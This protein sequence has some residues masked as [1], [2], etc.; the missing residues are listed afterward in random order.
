MS[1]AAATPPRPT[2]IF[3]HRQYSPALGVD[4]AAIPL[5]D[6]IPNLPEASPPKGLSADH[7]LEREKGRRK[8]LSR[9]RTQPRARRP[10]RPLPQ[11][12]AEKPRCKPVDRSA[13]RDAACA[14][15]NRPLGQWG[16]LARTL[17]SAA[18]RG[19]S[20]S[21]FLLA[22][23]V[24]PSGGVR[25]RQNVRCSAAA[26]QPARVPFCAS[27]VPK[28]H[29]AQRLRLPMVPPARRADDSSFAAS[30]RGV[31]RM[32]GR[33]CSGPLRSAMFTSTKSSETRI[34]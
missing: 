4:S 7:L 10:D 18:A 24:D 13:N 21:P 11:G 20:T 17:F 30:R 8:G 26:M 16:G 32:Q 5:R 33:T 23:L 34:S 15:R 28:M 1:V 29:R 3:R 6:G 2:T 14:S 27:G 12:S 9:K 22:F 25:S 31:R 19:E